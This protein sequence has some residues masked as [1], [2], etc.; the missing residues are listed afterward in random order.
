MATRSARSRGDPADA[1]Q[2]VVRPV[3]GGA[4]DDA[5]RSRDPARLTPVAGEALGDV[6]HRAHAGLVVGEVDDDRGRRRAGTGSGARV[7]APRSVRRSAARRRPAPGSRPAPARRP[8]PP[9][10]WRCCDG[11]GRRAWRARHA[12]ATTGR[13][14]GP[15]AAPPAGPR[16][17][18]TRRPPAATWRRIRGRSRL[19]REHPDRRPD[20]RAR[21]PRPGRRRR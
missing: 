11:P 19:H 9:A 6:E 15:V 8:R 12:T 10:H 21:S 7:P 14:A 13:D 17:A 2:G 5:Q 3:A 1:P 20:T 18:R 16:R 4:D